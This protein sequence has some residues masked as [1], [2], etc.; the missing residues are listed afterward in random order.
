MTGR[1]KQLAEKIVKMR[2]DGLVFAVDQ[3]F[4]GVKPSKVDRYD[5][6][7]PPPQKLSLKLQKAIEREETLQAENKALEKKMEDHEDLLTTLINEYNWA[8]E[9]LHQEQ[10]RNVRATTARLRAQRNETIINLHFDGEV[11]EMKEFL[12]NLPTIPEVLKMLSSVK[13]PI[14]ELEVEEGCL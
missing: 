4:R 10:Q 14:K 3:A 5:L 2:F 12:K 8:Q 9:D 6:D 1:Q 7:R 13:V 11:Q